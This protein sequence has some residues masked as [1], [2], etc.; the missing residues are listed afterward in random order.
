MTIKNNNYLEIRKFSHPDM[1]GVLYLWKECGLLFP[2]NDPV[3]DIELKVSFQPDLFLVGEAEGRI[4]A[5]LMAGYDGH[6]GWLN[7]LGVLPE[8]RGS[9]YAS[10]MVLHATAL[11]RELG[12][13][14]VNLQVRNSNMGVIEFYKKIG[15]YEHEVSSM[16]MK[17]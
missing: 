14:K 12:C 15:F 3:R 8:Y 5:T 10:Q 11:L 13:P 16:Q 1:T 6:R 17:L 2:G 9:G 4:A 7:Y